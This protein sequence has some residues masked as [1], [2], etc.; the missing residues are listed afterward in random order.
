LPIIAENDKKDLKRRFQKDLKKGVVI[1]LFTQTAS[2]L[3]IPGRPACPLCPQTQQLMDEVVALSPKLKLEVFDIHNQVAEAR[4]YGV[5]RIP[6]IVL[7]TNGEPNIKFYGI[8]SGYEFATF[9]DAIVDLSKGV[10]RLGV[11]MRKAL[12]KV[13]LP[14]HLQVFITPTCPHCP[15]AAALAYA[16][17]MEN[18]LVKADVIE[19]Q[20][21]PALSQ[22]YSIRTVPLTVINNAVTII[23]AVSENEMLSHIVRLGVKQPDEEKK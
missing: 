5:E 12:R 2:I 23:G 14:V 4:K 11:E 21:F 10:S 19:A 22:R 7:G 16:A 20:E 15:R 3:T 1:R 8:P 9:V 17:A 18:P 6:G 13:N